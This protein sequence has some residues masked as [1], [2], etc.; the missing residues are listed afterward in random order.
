MTRVVATREKMHVL[1][2]NILL[3]QNEILGASFDTKDLLKNAWLRM[4]SG[5][6]LSGAGEKTSKLVNRKNHR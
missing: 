4:K 5:T 3:S 6:R 1:L 2:V